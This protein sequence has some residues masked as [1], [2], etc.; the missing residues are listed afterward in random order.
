M[1]VDVRERGTVG[2]SYY[3]AREEK[4][5]LMEDV[6]LGGPEVVDARMDITRFPRFPLTR[7]Q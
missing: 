1:A 3:V 2:C 7:C 5:Y 6:K 4:L